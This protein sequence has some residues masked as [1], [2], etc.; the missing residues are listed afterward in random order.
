MPS[1]YTSVILKIRRVSG[2]VIPYEYNYYLALAFYSKLDKYNNEVRTIH[3]R[4]SIS[5]HTFSN[6]ISESVKYGINGLSLDRGFIIFR[7]I[8]KRMENYL[9]LAIAEDSHLRICDTTYVVQSI[10]STEK[11][12]LRNSYEFRTLSPVVVRNF[13]SRTKYVDSIDDL[14][15]NLKKNITWVLEKKLMHT[16]DRIEIEIKTGKRKTVR[17]SS[18]NKKEAITSGFNLTGSIEADPLTFD[19]LYHKGLGSKTGL[20][21]GCIEVDD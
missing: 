7:S 12:K 4:S 15:S 9:R 18:Q 8:D 19:L 2:N 13:E 6:I 14:G 21:L 16:P 3:D 1:D 20:G 5:F 11:P 10:I 17:I